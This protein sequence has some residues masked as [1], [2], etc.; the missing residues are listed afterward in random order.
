MKQ[1][2]TVLQIVIYNMY[3]C[4]I[5]QLSHILCKSVLYDT[6]NYPITHNIAIYDIKCSSKTCEIALYDVTI[7]NT[8]YAEINTICIILN[9]HI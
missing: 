6:L 4:T 3:Y 5:N 1:P 2:Y 7:I 8:L 9:C